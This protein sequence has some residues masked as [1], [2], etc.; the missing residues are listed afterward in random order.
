MPPKEVA[1][2]TSRQLVPVN[3]VS[4]VGRSVTWARHNLTSENGT[5]SSQPSLALDDEERLLELLLLRLCTDGATALEAGGGSC[6][7]TCKCTW[8]V[9]QSTKCNGILQQ[10]K[11]SH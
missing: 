5:P 2:L 7:V 8:Q 11:H 3:L 6:Q 4:A 9:T 10:C 1:A